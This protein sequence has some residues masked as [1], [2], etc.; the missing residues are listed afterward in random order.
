MTPGAGAHWCESR[1]SVRC[2]RFLRRLRRRTPLAAP[3]DTAAAGPGRVWWGTAVTVISAIMSP[4]EKPAGTALAH[5]SPRTAPPSSRA[6]TRSSDNEAAIASLFYPLRRR[7]RSRRDLK[8]G[9]AAPASPQAAHPSRAAARGPGAGGVSRAISLDWP[10]PRRDRGH[11][12]RHAYSRIATHQAERRQPGPG[13]GLV[14]ESEFTARI[15]PLIE[16]Y[17]SA[18]A[19]KLIRPF[20]NK[21]LNF[22]TGI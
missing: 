21:Q 5:P 9:A 19:G 10:G 17:Q 8:K 16:L 4:A 12:W 22:Q 6:M 7:H 3:R 14:L 11:C 20:Q 13:P 2:R 1:A 18:A 15:R